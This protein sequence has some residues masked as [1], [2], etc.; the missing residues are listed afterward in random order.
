MNMH[1]LKKIL[2]LLLA[3]VL[4]LGTIAAGTPE[5]KAESNQWTVS[6]GFDGSFIWEGS[7]YNDNM[8]D[9]FSNDDDYGRITSAES[10]DTSVFI[11]K[12]ESWSDGEDTYR[13][14]FLKPRNAGVAE[15]TIKFTAPSG[16]QETVTTAITVRKYPKEI[17]SLK[18]NGRVVNTGKYKYQVTRKI[19]KSSSTVKIK[20][21]LKKGWKITSLSAY[22]SKSG[23]EGSFRKFKVTRN[24]LFK[25][26]SIKVPKKY[27]YFNIGFTMR[28]GSCELNYLIRLR[29]KK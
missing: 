2:S 4:V 19:S 10:G 11:V 26:S 8:I 22:R 25:G 17:K 3:F 6:V 14:F 9:V 20:M 16:E 23:K 29:R 1:S 27:K 12:E 21:A 18:I 5:V 13:S 24:Q 28:K 15:L 7:D